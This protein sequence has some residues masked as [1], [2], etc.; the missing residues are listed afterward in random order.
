M[1]R[2]GKRVYAAACANDPQAQ[3]DLRAVVKSLRGARYK[4]VRRENDRARKRPVRLLTSARPAPAAF[5]PAPL[6]AMQNCILLL[7]LTNPPTS[8]IR[9]LPSAL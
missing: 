8:D 4:R 3:A 2:L 6:Y 5:D 9:H 1:I 7:L